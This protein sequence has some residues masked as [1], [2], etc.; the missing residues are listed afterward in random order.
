MKRRPLP[1]AGELTSSGAVNPLATVEKFSRIDPFWISGTGGVG[2]G[3]G[4]ALRPASD[5]RSRRDNTARAARFRFNDIRPAR[6]Q[7]GG[8]PTKGSFLIVFIPVQSQRPAG[9]AQHRKSNTV[10][11]LSSRYRV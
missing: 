3:V 7:A 5:V 2:V 4:S 10:V 9:Y 6:L 1:S 8:S 11:T